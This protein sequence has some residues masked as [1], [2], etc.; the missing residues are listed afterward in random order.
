MPFAPIQRRD[1]ECARRHI[2]PAILLL[3]LVLAACSPNAPERNVMDVDGQETPT[4]SASPA[5]LSPPAFNTAETATPSPTPTA[6]PRY[7]G[8]W[9]ANE[10]LCKDGAWEFAEMDLSTAGEVHCDFHRVREAPGGY[11]IDATCTAEGTRTPD[12]I[13]LRFAES[14]GAMLV[15]SKTF[16]PVGLIPCK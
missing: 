7:V 14:A 5:P 13:K 1:S 10:K 12:T 2:G 11:D 8:R 4:T 3:V 6:A 15:E 16:S 9:A